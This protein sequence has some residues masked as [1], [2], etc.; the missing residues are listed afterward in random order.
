[1]SQI[2]LDFLFLGLRRKANNHVHELTRDNHRLGARGSDAKRKARR[3]KEKK[4]N[5]RFS[6]R[7]R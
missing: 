1:L 3:A 6:F 7:K 2:S 5:A 4:Q